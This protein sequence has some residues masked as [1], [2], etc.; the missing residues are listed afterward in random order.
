MNQKK[1]EN[2]FLEKRLEAF[3][4]YVRECVVFG[5][6]ESFDEQV[7]LLKLFLKTEIELKAKK[8]E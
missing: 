5:S 8:G 6:M 1:K 2:E 7:E 3:N 4:Q